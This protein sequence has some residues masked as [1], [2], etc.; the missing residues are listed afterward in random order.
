MIKMV[1]VLH[2]YGVVKFSFLH[3]VNLLLFNIMVKL[4]L[5]FIFVRQLFYCLFKLTVY[6]V[7][8]FQN[9]TR[10]ISLFL[11]SD[12]SV[13]LSSIVVMVTLS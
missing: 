8:N 7:A 11:S 4:L 12:L 13:C 10:T 9:K 3:F 5:F 2:F 6:C 1:V